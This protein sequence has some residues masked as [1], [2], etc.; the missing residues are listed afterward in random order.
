MMRLISIGLWVCVVAL[1]SSYGAAYW[2]AGAASSKSDSAHPGGLEYRRTPAVT[3]PMIIDG[4]VRGYVIAKLIFTADTAALHALRIEPQSFV[5]SAAFD[6]IYTN[7]RMDTS[8]LSKYNLKEMLDNIKSNVNKKFN[9]D[10]IQD[11]LVDSINYIDK[12]D[13]RKMSEITAPAGRG[14]A[15]EKPAKSAH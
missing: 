3:V 14:D 2:A 12:N 6:E 5:T 4:S 7:G 9:G 13:I 10:V 15:A 1:L 11:V 8:K